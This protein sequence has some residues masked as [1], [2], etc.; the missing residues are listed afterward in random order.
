ML[1]R[2]RATG[3]VAVVAAICAVAVSPAACD[4]SG[5]AA[6]LQTVRVF[7][8]ASLTAAFSDMARAFEAQHAACRVALHFAG[9]PQLVL[10][11]REGAAA[12]VF[13][14]ADAITM[15]R[16]VAT[17]R[18]ADKPLVF[19]RNRL[20]IAVGSG[21]ARGIRGLADL[22]RPDVKVALCAPE[23]PAGH[24]A[25]Q[26][27]AKA[28]VVVRSLS[29]EANVKALVAKVQLG[30]LDAAI[31]YATDVRADGVEG[32]ELDPAHDV[33]AD[34]PIAA[35]GAGGAEAPAGAIAFVTFVRSDGGRAILR[36]HGFLLP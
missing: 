2:R 33:L 30:E 9:S 35:L 34:Y 21:N 7:A 15:Q 6:T 17:G 4:G 16:V 29:D 10:Q 28:G 19:A 12:D 1:V 26:V 14:A 5:P 31:V 36:R 18:V 11:L 3:R 25:R 27:L 22:A 32:I 23:V 13:A 24:Y 20:A 8:A